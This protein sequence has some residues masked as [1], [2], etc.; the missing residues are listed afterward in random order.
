MERLGT[1]LYE[2]NYRILA[3]AVLKT[4]KLEREGFTAARA[5]QVA[6]VVKNPLVNAGDVRDVG[7]IPGMGR[8][9]GEGQ[10]NPF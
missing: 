8:A 9:P 6:P 1:W 4:S 7:S 2:Q 5:S 3:A 10:G